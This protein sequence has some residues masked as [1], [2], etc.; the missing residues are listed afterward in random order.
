M[1]VTWLAAVK[2][3]D[4]G[5]LI[6][7]RDFAATQT[8]DEEYRQEVEYGG[9]FGTEGPVWRH[10]RKA[11]EDTVSFTARILKTGAAKG[12]IDEEFVKDRLLPDFS[13]VLRRADRRV[14]LTGCNWTRIAINST[15]DASTLTMDVSHPGYKPI[16]K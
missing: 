8:M 6:E 1:A 4:L 15:L 10:V 16:V 5:L 14:A 3:K 7:N 2:A 9:A 12:M 13:M 11:N